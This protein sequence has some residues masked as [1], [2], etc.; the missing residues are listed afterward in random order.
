M[1]NDTPQESEIKVTLTAEEAD[2]LM[3]GL[4]QDEIDMIGI[5]LMELE[6]GMD[7]LCPEGLGSTEVDW[8]AA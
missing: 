8:E 5:A 7:E 6:Q 3:D 1:T 2:L 4:T